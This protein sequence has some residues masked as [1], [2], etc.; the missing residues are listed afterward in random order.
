MAFDD[1]TPSED[2]DDFETTPYNSYHQEEADKHQNQADIDAMVTEDL[3]TNPRYDA[4]FADYQPVLRPDFT[5]HYVLHRQRWV[6]DGQADEN[7]PARQLNFFEREAYVSLWAIQQKKLF[8]LQCRW[9][10]EEVRDVP[11]LVIT[12]DFDTLSAGI[13]NCTAVPPITPEELEMYLDWVRQADYACDL[14]DQYDQRWAWQHY[15]LIRE[16]LAPAAPAA[17]TRMVATP[18]ALPDW[19]RFHNQQTGNDRVLYLPDV[20][21]QKEERIWDA[22]REGQ[23]EQ[24]AIAAAAGKAPDPR[25]SSLPAEELERLAEA[26]AQRFEEPRVNRWRELSQLLHPPVTAADRELQFIVAR[27]QVAKELI[28][29]A[30][31][32]DWREATRQA[33]YAYC[34][35][36]LLEYLPRVYEEYRQRLDWG[37]A[38]P[39]R[40]EWDS[41]KYNLAD[42]FRGWLLQGR[43]RLGE[44]E[45][46][47]F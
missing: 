7:H 16:T 1:A 31:G 25:P 29:V 47:D 38:Q 46:F 11:G 12:N 20:R 8:D 44:P 13:E 45:D 26:F 5:R 17:A 18:K 15:R 35:R 32:A 34:H 4:F 28:P 27:M 21:G 42:L 33:H 41:L 3:L 9:R 2:D 37:I 39:R 10:A 22:W 24:E 23:R 14:N 40:L 19:Y 6:E 43:A 36:Q 30:A